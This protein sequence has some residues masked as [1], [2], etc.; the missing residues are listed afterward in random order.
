MIHKMKLNESPFERIKN[1][2][3][4]IEF[5]LYD[6]KRRKIKIGDKIEF[7]KLPDLREVI[8]VDV[9]DLYREESFEK[10]FKK[11]YTDEEEIKS[12]TKSMYNFY[13]PEKEK[14]YGVLGIK[15]SLLKNNFRY[16]YN[17]LVRDKIPEEIDRES[18]RKCK[19][20]ILDDE[21]YLKELNKK[22]LE[23]ANEFI[24]KDSIE[25]LG[26]LMEVLNAIMKQKGYSIEEVKKIMKVK[27]QKKGAFNNKIF[28]EY[29][30]EEKRNIE[31]E[32]ELSKDFRKEKVEK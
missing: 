19:Y 17:K 27:E 1:G 26:D 29:I 21:E 28:L 15:I 13:S 9:I 4:T 7:S 23:E 2:T 24:E 10:L 25:E 22:V 11:L 3:K 20:R 18:G 8:L 12:K 14:E 6:E 31:E 5:R 30:D 16:T 32:K